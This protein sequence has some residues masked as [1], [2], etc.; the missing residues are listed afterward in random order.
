MARIMVG[1]CALV[2]ASGHALGEPGDT[3]ELWRTKTGDTRVLDVLDAAS[4]VLPGGLVTVDTDGLVP[5]V[6]PEVGA[7]SACF[8]SV[9]GG[10]RQVLLALAPNP[11]AIEDYLTA[12]PL[13]GVA[14]DHGVSALIGNPATETRAAI[15]TAIDRA[16]VQKFDEGGV[17]LRPVRTPT[18]APGKRFPNGNVPYKILW[19]S[20]NGT[21]YATARDK[22]LRKS[23]DRGLT[24]T[25]RGYHANG[26]GGSQCFVRTSAGTLLTFKV[27]FPLSNT[28]MRSTDDGATW[29]EVHDEAARR[30][31]HGLAPMH[32]TS[33]L[34]DPNTGYIYWGE[35]QSTDTAADVNV[36]RSTDDGAT[37]TTFHTFPGPTSASA[38]KIRHVHSLE[39]DHVMGRVVVMLGDDDPKA[40]IYR[41]N[42]AGTGF[43][44]LITNDQFAAWPSSR[45][46]RAI[47]YIPFPDYIVYGGDTMSNTYI[48][49]MARTEIGKTNPVVER[50][51]KANAT[52]WFAQKAS[53]D[54]SRWLMS[55][56]Q[57]S[58]SLR[59]DSAAHIYA[60]ENQGDVVTEV[61]VVGANSGNFAMVYPLGG[62][63]PTGGG[64]PVWFGIQ[65][66][67]HTYT[68]WEA[69]VARA[70]GSAL[71]Q[72]DP[73]PYVTG[74]QSVSS[75]QVVLAGGSEHVF[76]VATA[77]ATRFRLH[78]V[79]LRALPTA[80]AAL[81]MEIQ[82]SGG[83]VIWA[84]PATGTPGSQRA[85]MNEGWSPFIADFTVPVGYEFHFVLK[86]TAAGSI[87]AVAH[88]TFGFGGE[89]A[90]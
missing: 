27:D 76:A 61:A 29:T 86:N 62:S 22:T 10:P 8:A 58:P 23:V 56:S 48:M 25:K 90:P 4:G 46:A 20:A 57:E 87:T 63:A 79:A 36:Y 47:S 33:M 13:V 15:D 7:A 60:I 42:S 52:L 37:W 5:L 59:L 73:L 14:T 2:D 1:G 68:T 21:L 85:Y 16:T 41:M 84:T 17:I 88:A 55:A 30:T 67:T 19:A 28:L 53:Q 12:H 3:V 78:E 77:S 35:Y 50:L 24:W 89:L 71:H 74:L 31:S 75:G 49:R 82:S 44:P 11:A 18:L 72:A 64:D 51:Y 38:D 69:K 81:K 45:W 66:G 40:G 6:Q 65:E 83:A 54:G 32:C 43:E 39:Y 70:G 26:F 34:Q 9:G 80:S